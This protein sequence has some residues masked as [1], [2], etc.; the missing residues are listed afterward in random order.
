[1]VTAE[2]DVEELLGLVMSVGRSVQE[3]SR[4]MDSMTEIVKK[5]MFIQKFNSHY[6][7]LS[8]IYNIF[9]IGH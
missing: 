3:S 4:V 7:N 2:T 9:K 5:V 1:M 6:Y 8:Y